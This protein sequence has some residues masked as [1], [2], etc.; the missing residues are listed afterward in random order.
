MRPRLALMVFVD[1]AQ[2]PEAY[3]KKRANQAL[4]LKIRDVRAGESSPED[5]RNRVVSP[6]PEWI[7][8]N[9]PAAGQPAT[10]HNTVLLNRLVPILGTGWKITARRRQA[11]GDRKLVEAYQLQGDPSHGFLLSTGAGSTHA[12]GISPLGASSSGGSRRARVSNRSMI[13]RAC[14][15]DGSSAASP[16]T[17]TTRSCPGASRGW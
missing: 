5:L 2:A 13:M 10:S 15:N 14:S 9:N 3:E 4:R 12:D 11:G 6:R 7:A 8:T 1:A 16:R 17:I